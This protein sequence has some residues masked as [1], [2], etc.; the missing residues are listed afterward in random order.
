MVLEGL[1]KPFAAEKKPYELF[2][3]GIL[4]SSVGIVLG[5]FIFSPFSS[6]VCISL[7]ALVCVPLIYGVIKMEERKSLEIKK[8]WILVKE[9]GRALLFFT[10][11]FLGFVVSFSLWYV[12]LP[13]AQMTELF[14]VQTATISEVKN[15]AGGATGMIVNPAG[16]VASLMEHNSR[17]LLFCLLFAFFYGFGA[18][19]ILTWNASVVGAAIGDIVRSNM[20]SGFFS[21]FSASLVKYMTHGIPE[22]VAYFTAGLAGGIISIAVINHDFKSPAFRRVLRDSLDLIV[23]SFAMLFVAA[24]L[25][26]FVS[27]YL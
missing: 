6:I 2:W 24:L 12:F 27:P 5:L 17:V 19:F 9:H 21:A 14:S 15:D 22:I 16:E 23:L 1:I 20:G 3:L 10:F 8:E 4:F 13:E 7:T 26:V 11:L 25:E 18:I